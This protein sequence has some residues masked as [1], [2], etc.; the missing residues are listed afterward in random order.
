MGEKPIP[1]LLLLLLLICTFQPGALGQPKALKMAESG[2]SQSLSGQLWYWLEPPGN[3]AVPASLDLTQFRP[4]H[5]KSVPA[6]AQRTWLWFRIHNPGGVAQRKILNFEEILF[7]RMQLFSR[8][9]GP[10]QSQEAGLDLP[11]DEWPLGYRYIALPLTVQP[12]T[13]DYFVAFETRHWPLLQ[14][15]LTDLQYLASSGV[16]GTSV[17]TLSIGIMVGILVLAAGIVWRG[18]RQ[19]ALY[20]FI[21]FLVFSILLGV[22]MGGELL[23]WLPQ[24]S[25]HFSEIY[26]HFTTG[27]VLCALWLTRSLFQPAQD[28]PWLERLL[29]L[30][31]FSYVLL[32]FI[33]LL[34]DIPYL[35]TV[36]TTLSGFSF[37]TLTSTGLLYWYRGHPAGRSYSLALL[38][39]QL[40]ALPAIL[41]GV[42]VIPYFYWSRH[43]YELATVAMSLLFARALADKLQTLYEQQGQLEHKAALAEEAN[44]AKGNF[45]ARMSHEIR[46]PIN[47]VLG[48]TEVL[49]QTSLSVGQRRYVDVIAS[50]GKL[51]LEIVNDIL[52]YSKLEAGRVELEH[53]PFGLENVLTQCIAIFVPA[54]HD[55][56]LVLSVA[57]HPDTPLALLGDPTRLQQILNNLISNA[58]KFTAHGT[59]LTQVSHRPLRGNRIELRVSV[60]DPGIGIPREKIGQLF[61]PFTQGDDSTTRRYGGTGLGLSISRQLAQMMNGDIQ[62]ESEPG[63]GTRFSL[64]AEMEI[65]P[66][67]ETEIRRKRQLMAGKKMLLVYDHPGYG[68]AMS[69]YFR[70]WGMEII[71]ATNL[72]EARQQ[73]SQTSVDVIFSSSGLILKEPEALSHLPVA[74]QPIIV[75]QAMFD[76]P[77]RETIVDTEILYLDSPCTITDI[78]DA[79]CDAMHIDPVNPFI[80]TGSHLIAPPRIR[81]LVAEDNPVNRHVIHAMLE[82]LGVDF[83]FAENGLEVVQRYRKLRDH[84]ALILMDCEM[85]ELDGFGATRSIRTLEQEQH[86][87]RIP[88]VAVT[89]HALADSGQ[90]CLDAGMDAVLTKPV[91]LAELTRVLTRYAGYTSSPEAEPDSSPQARQAPGAS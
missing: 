13:N 32:S 62:V 25:H 4:L 69:R 76:P 6:I 61:Q 50:S 87:Q 78:L 17:H 83:Q 89:A 15:Q 23:L 59:I 53:I 85:P 74:G 82:R 64:T 63:R 70:D 2:G 66:V 28:Y 27:I 16:N 24:S 43:C 14:P 31:M 52:D 75:L 42:G 60:T 7:D 81:V 18:Y 47:G 38:G 8:E 21:G 12:G 41:G 26:L 10:W 79:L 58:I 44:Q 57:T 71:R 3:A 84:Y 65:D 88:I 19:P 1:R 73:L 9:S 46:T 39:Y 80:D 86:W 91:S 33:A 72:S 36:Q 22:F 37:A 90:R 35:F 30:V 55:K 29:Q 34:T 54:A 40:L 77:V 67:R 45:M 68:D 11:R 56:G 48:M 5:Q 20:A 51:L 49:T